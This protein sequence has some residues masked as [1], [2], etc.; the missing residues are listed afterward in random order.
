MFIVEVHLCVDMNKP[1]TVVVGAETEI[2][3][4]GQRMVLWV[5][6]GSKQT[7]PEKPMDFHH[8]VCATFPSNTSPFR[9]FIAFSTPQ[10]TLTP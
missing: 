3:C 9:P 5:G 10:L 7:P 8:E 2:C 6:L 4:E 1:Y